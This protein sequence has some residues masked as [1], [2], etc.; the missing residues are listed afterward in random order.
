MK[1][2]RT[3]EDLPPFVKS[4]NQ[5]YRLL[6]VWLIVLIFLLYLFTTYFE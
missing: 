4:W 3:G 1:N 2:S 5:F 6:V